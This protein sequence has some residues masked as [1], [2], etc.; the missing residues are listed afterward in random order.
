MWANVY[1]ME[2]NWR[3]FCGLGDKEC[4]ELEQVHIFWIDSLQIIQD[5][6]KTIKNPRRDSKISSF[7]VETE[8]GLILY[9]Y[10]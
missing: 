10:E 8:D 4:V 6:T 2:Q 9:E 7:V 3:L 5:G 1:S